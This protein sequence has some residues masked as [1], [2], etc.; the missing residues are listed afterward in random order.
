MSPVRNISSGSE[1]VQSG[2]AGNKKFRFDKVVT[3]FHEGE[4]VSQMEGETV[5]EGQGDNVPQGDGEAVCEVDSV[6]VTQEDG[7]AV[8]EGERET[9]VQGNGEA[10]CEGDSSSGGGP[11]EN[12][13]SFEWISIC[14]FW[15]NQDSLNLDSSQ[16][17]DVQ[18]GA[19]DIGEGRKGNLDRPSQRGDVPAGTSGVVLQA[20]EDEKCGVCNLVKNR[21]A[22]M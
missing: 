14:E 11:T 19:S 15:K 10:V 1:E 9:V 6:T 7:E 16:G 22:D 17:G 5:Q 12:S 2:S 13:L 21:Y 4:A 20:R 18:S 3:V 8:R